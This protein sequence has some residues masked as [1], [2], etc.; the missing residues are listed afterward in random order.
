MSVVEGVAD[1]VQV[2]VDKDLVEERVQEYL[3][4]V[5]EGGKVLAKLEITKEGVVKEVKEVEMVKDDLV[6]VEV[7]DS[8]QAKVEGEILEE[9]EENMVGK[10]D[11]VVLEEV[12]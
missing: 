1:P 2:L 8:V 5:V 10:V 6:K 3:E 4:K 7:V 11:M 12:K 9:V